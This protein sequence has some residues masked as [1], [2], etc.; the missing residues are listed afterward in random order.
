[1]LTSNAARTSSRS[2]S[3]ILYRT[4]PLLKIVICVVLASS[5]LVLHQIWALSVLIAVLVTVG[6]LA[7]PVNIKFVAY[8]AIA[9]L[10]F[11]ALSTWVRDLHTSIVS[12]LRLVAMVL[13]APILAYTT[14]PTD[15]VRSLQT[16]RLPGFLV[17]S[18]M[19]IWRFLPLIH[20]E[21]QRIIEANQLRGVDIARQPRH[22]FS[23][24]FMPLIFRIVAY[25]DDVTIGLETRGY[26]PT[27]PR[28]ISQPLTWRWSDIAIAGCAVGLV[29]IIGYMEWLA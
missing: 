18:L 25:A 20:Q 6:L 5:A 15:L 19:L 17:L 2:G 12:A 23:G 7:L 21:A 24:L 11:I 26:D 16:V 1:M 3:S 29:A 8:S 4:N 28:S 22:W 10:L 13:P 14:A 27:A 9:L